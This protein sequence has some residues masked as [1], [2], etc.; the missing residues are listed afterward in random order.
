M[1]AIGAMLLIVALRDGELSVLYPI[2]ALSFVW[3]TLISIFLFHEYVS[4]Y[5]W[6]GVAAIL[7]GVSLIGY[8]SKNI[9]KPGTTL[10][11]P[12]VETRQ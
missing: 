8:G 3:V 1:Y 6:V 11:S 9:S 2:I 10:N 5:N 4:A 7:L 12:L